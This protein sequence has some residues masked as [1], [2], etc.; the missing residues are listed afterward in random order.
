MT[1]FCIKCTICEAQLH[2][3]EYKAHVRSC[4]IIKVHTDRK[5]VPDAADIHYQDQQ[6]AFQRNKRAGEWVPGKDPRSV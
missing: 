4:V 6:L 1:A 5:V 3:W 2:V